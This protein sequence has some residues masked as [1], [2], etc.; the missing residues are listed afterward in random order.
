MKRAG[1]AGVRRT[2]V[3]VCRLSSWHPCPAPPPPGS[4]GPV[5]A[6]PSPLRSSSR[7]KGP[8]EQGLPSLA[9]D[10]R[11]FLSCTEKRVTLPEG[12]GQGCQAQS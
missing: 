8:S 7:E 1:P 5:S 2:K 4:S 10:K 11:P 3:A 6:S 12:P 9:A